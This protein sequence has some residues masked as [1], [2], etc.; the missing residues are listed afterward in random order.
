VR[1]ECPASFQFVDADDKLKLI[2]H[3]TDLPPEMRWVQFAVTDLDQEK[4]PLICADVVSLICVTQRFL[5]LGK[6]NR[7]TTGTVSCLSA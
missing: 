6:T 2:G 1:D 7:T 3:Q 4:E 5:L